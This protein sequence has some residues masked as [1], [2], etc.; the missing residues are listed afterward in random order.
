MGATLVTSMQLPTFPSPSPSLFSTLSSSS[1]DTSYNGCYSALSPG[2][3]LKDVRMH[4]YLPVL[5]WQKAVTHDCMYNNYTTSKKEVFPL[6][7]EP[8]RY[9]IRLPSPRILHSHPTL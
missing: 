6:D 1:C 3:K 7:L 2:R 4:K 5:I 8:L 9:Q